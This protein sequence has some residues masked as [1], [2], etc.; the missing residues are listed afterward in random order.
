MDNFQTRPTCCGKGCGCVGYGYVP[1]Q[2]MGETYCP[3]TGL[4]QGTV[5]PELDLNICEY[6]KICKQWRGE[7]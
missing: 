5:F 3:A 1:E 4:M 6:G 7:Q 2:V